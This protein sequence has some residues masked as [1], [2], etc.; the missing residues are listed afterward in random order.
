VVI[1][2]GHAGGGDGVVG[3]DGGEEFFSAEHLL[4]VVVLGAFLLVDEVQ[5]G[6]LGV[7]LRQVLLVDGPL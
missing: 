1:V 5:A 7:G 4:G 2:A 6:L 3:I